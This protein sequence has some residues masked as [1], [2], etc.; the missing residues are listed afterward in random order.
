VTPTLHASLPAAALAALLA[1]APA[2][3]QVP[4]SLAQVPVP[5]PR[6]LAAFVA[7]KPAAVRLGKALFWDMQVG[8]DGLTACAS[9]HF[10][11][12]TDDRSR[13]TLHPGADGAFDAGGRAN[14]DVALAD[15]P[16]HQLADP[17]DRFSQRLRSRDDVVGAQG[18]PRTAFQRLVAGRAEE[19]G[20]TR[21]DA[22]F[23][24][25]ARNVRQVTGRNAPSVVNAVFNFV[26]FWDGRASHHFNGVNPFGVMDAGATV[27]RL[28]SGALVPVSL[29]ADLA[30]N[31]F[32]LDNASLASQAVGPVPNDVEMSWSGR[33]WPEIGRKLLPL[34]PLAKQ[35]VHPNDSTLRTLRAPSGKGL[36]TTYRDMVKAAFRPEWWSGPD[37]G[38]HAHIEANFA[39]FFGLAVQLYEATLVS[40]DTP[41]D[42]FLRGNPTAL[43]PRQLAGMSI[44]FSDGA[45]C[46]FCHAGPELTATTRTQLLAPGEPGMIELMAMGD[47]LLANYD[48][49]FYDI[50]VRPIAEDLGRGGRVTLGGRSLPLAFTSQFF[51]HRDPV[52]GPLPFEPLAQ[53]GCVND[54]FA[55][56]P[57]VCP[58]PAITITREAVR[59]AFKVP[60]L[61]NVELTGPYMH[62][63]GMSTL[64]Q[65]VDFYVRG[66][67]FHEENLETVDPIVAGI[68][69][70]VGDEAR[71]REL[72]DFL[73]ALTDE[74]VRQE[75]APFDHPQLLVADGHHLR[76]D[77]DPKRARTL[78]DRLREIPAV[79]AAGRQAQGLPP[80]R[81][82]LAGDA[83]ADP[84]HHFRR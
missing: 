66:G 35:A 74:R 18:V 47:G 65:V 10:S 44:F 41:F 21:R 1:A 61:R 28:E 46:M 58:P 24:H 78:A 3:G 37:A 20:R 57:Q 60:G 12:G 83:P 62:N 53:P 38:G 25:A 34:A 54:P 14:E 5:E 73:L 43:T 2:R 15:F 8:S 81:A 27:L 76:V 30:T 11:A 52:L 4:V 72:V 80:V 36:A 17:D 32:A 40:D 70:L 51:E 39:L 50:G 55:D 22:V 82:F 64:M 33:T 29:V 19:R 71:K 13:N 79:G 42:R 9:C 49:G 67:D 56:P 68:Q 48:I 16:F 26:N 63:G 23:E 6:N 77:G 31:P 45:S 69:G 84:E 7:D 75:S 59:G